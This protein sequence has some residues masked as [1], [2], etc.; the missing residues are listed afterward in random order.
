M[1]NKRQRFSFKKGV[2][3]RVF[4]SPFFVLRYQ[5]KVLPEAHYS[6]VVGKRVD[7]KAVIRNRVKRQLMKNLEE[8][9]ENKSS[10]LDIVIYGRKGILNATSKESLGELKK[11]LEQIK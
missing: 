7:K 11:A 8:L 10:D 6:V 1:F 9:F 3:K 2:P 5:R 4:T